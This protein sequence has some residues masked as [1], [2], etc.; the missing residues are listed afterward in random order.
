MNTKPK[1]L[2]A[3]RMQG[4][5]VEALKRISARPG[6]FYSDR[7]VNWLISQAVREFIER[8]DPQPAPTDKQ[9]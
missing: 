8:N 1:D 6:A 3:I 4:E 9:A 5:L 2:T 7:S